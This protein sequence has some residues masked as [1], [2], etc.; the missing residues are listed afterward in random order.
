MTHERILRREDAALVI[1][2]V[3]EAFRK[4][5]YDFTLMTKNILILGK[6]CQLLEIP[7]LVTE[8]YPQGLGSTVTELA[9]LA[10]GSQQFEKSCFSCCQYEPFSDALTI[11][12]RSQ[13]IVAGI[14]AHVCVNQTVHDLLYTKY[15]V[16]LAADAIG[17][18]Y[19]HNKEIALQKM[20]DSGAIIS[21]VE[22]CIFEMLRMSGTD[23]FKQVQKLLK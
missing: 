2:D 9:E 16:H 12:G 22:M 14:E 15:Q 7:I 6:A 21:S 11:L 18:R 4:Y 3:Q 23:L 17:S 13:V 1:V 19:P 10:A 5:I 20:R 8:Q